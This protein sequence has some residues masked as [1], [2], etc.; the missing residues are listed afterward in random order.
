MSIGLQ[1]R[2]ATAPPLRIGRPEV[3]P[4]PPI[5][6]LEERTRAIGRELFVRMDRAGRRRGLRDRVYDT[7]M[8][9]T[10]ADTALKTQLFR[11]IDVLPALRTPEQVARHVREHLLHPELHLPAPVRAVLAASESSTL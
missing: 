1:D 2:A 10:M 4:A 5:P 7:V 9:W 8:Q 3:G 6:E 11:L